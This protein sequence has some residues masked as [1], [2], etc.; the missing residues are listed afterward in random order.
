ML[1]NQLGRK[2]GR[3]KMS[4]FGMRPRHTSIF[5]TTLTGIF[6]ALLT[7]SLAAL[8][9][10]DVRDVIT[11]SQERIRAYQQREQDLRDQLRELEVEVQKGTIVWHY[12]ERIALGTVPAGS[13][14]Q[15]VAR[16]MKDMLITANLLSVIKNNRIA[17][18][19]REEPLEP[20]RVLVE[21][22]P[23]D[24]E[25]WVQDL[26][27]SGETVGLW[28][29]VGKNCLY[30]DSV[31]VS[32]EAFPVEKVFEEGHVVAELEV[33]PGEFLVNWYEFL[34][35]LRSSALRQGMIEMND[36]LGGGVTTDQLREIGRQVSSR[37]G[38][39]RLVAVANRDLYQS[40]TLDVR[41]E[42][43][44]DDLAAVSR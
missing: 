32:V 33:E 13:D 11:G 29:V 34:D 1:G 18:T 16:N 15:G 39:C 17:V 2:I 37:P 35:R 5:I 31:P 19:R 36:S 14:A 10:R 26:S 44:T 20:G 38:A 40:S 7:L 9:S 8:F 43:R 3:R 28:L 4:V 42:V 27:N 25:K 6:I 21:Y 41:I 22:E 30:R 23:A 12:G 24:L